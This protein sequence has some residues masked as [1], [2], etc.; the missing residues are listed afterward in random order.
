LQLLLSGRSPQAGNPVPAA[1]DLLPGTGHPL[2]TRRR[3]APETAH[4]Q[5]ISLI[6]IPGPVAGNPLHIVAVR[7]LIGR[8]F[9]D[10]LGRLLFDQRRW[11]RPRLR[12]FSIRLMDGTACHNIDTLLRRGRGWR[13]WRERFFLCGDM[14]NQQRSGQERATQ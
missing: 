1:L 8:Q 14:G 6:L 13:G 9:I 5:I 2:T 7:F 12:G 10:R 3:G 4:P 11:L